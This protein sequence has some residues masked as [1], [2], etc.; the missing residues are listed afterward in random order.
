MFVDTPSNIFMSI[1]PNSISEIFPISQDMLNP[2]DQ[3]SVL[4]KKTHRENDS[5][6][7]QNDEYLLKK[8]NKIKD[9]SKNEK[10][11]SKEI[12]KENEKE[13]QQNKVSTDDETLNKLKSEKI[14]ER[15]KKK[16]N[17]SII[18]LKDLNDWILKTTNL[19]E[20]KKKSKTKL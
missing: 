17:F 12:I 7:S 10:E 9:I 1:E 16:D 19:N 6:H 2:D 3:E 5:N 8:D 20:A 13:I 4:G 15:K 18:L 14:S 11:E